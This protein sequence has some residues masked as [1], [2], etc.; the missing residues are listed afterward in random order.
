MWQDVCLPEPAEGFPATIRATLPS[1]MP[2]GSSPTGQEL[3]PF[4]KVE[5]CRLDP[6]VVG[7]CPEMSGI[8]GGNSLRVAHPLAAVCILASCCHTLVLKQPSLCQHVWRWSPWMSS[9]SSLISSCLPPGKMMQNSPELVLESRPLSPSP[10]ETVSWWPVF[11]IP[12]VTWQDGS[13]QSADWAKCVYPTHLVTD[14][15]LATVHLSSTY[16]MSSLDTQR[17]FQNS[18]EDLVLHWLLEQAVVKP[19]ASPVPRMLLWE[20]LGYLTQAQCQWG[21]DTDSHPHYCCPIPGQDILCV[22]C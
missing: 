15:C 7:S 4:S 20:H 2:K 1:L 8:M 5:H 3:R 11:L 13:H 12:V 6:I 19:D 17:V 16:L 14:V 10:T 21:V 22:Q 18:L 9:L